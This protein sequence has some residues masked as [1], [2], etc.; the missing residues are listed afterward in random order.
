MPQ[1]YSRTQRISDQI[2]KYL[3]QLIQSELKDPRVGMVTI[4]AVDVSRELDVARV[5]FSSYGG[6]GSNVVGGEP[7]SALEGLTRAAGYLRSALAKR[8]KIRTTPKLIFV[9]DESIAYG[10]RLSSLIDDAMDEA[11]DSQ[12]QP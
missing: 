5:Y 6:G 4:T 11:T 12:D 3:A 10:N 9:L 7:D 2:Q 1:D 8:L